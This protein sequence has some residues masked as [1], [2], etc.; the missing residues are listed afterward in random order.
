MGI[1]CYEQAVAERSFRIEASK[2][3]IHFNIL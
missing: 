3:T 1:Y 2:F